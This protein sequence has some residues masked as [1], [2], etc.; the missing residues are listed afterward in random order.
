[1]N[2]LII[3]AGSVGLVLGTTLLEAGCH[4]SFFARGATLEAIRTDGVHRQG[5]F[6]PLDFPP[7]AVE[8]AADQYGEFPDGHFDFILISAKTMANA[9][10]SDALAEHRGLLA[11]EG[12][13][14]ILQ[15]GWGNDAE[16]LRNFP[17]EQICSARVITGCQRS[18]PNSSTVTVYTAPLLLGNLYGLDTAPLEPLAAAFCAGGFPCEVTDEVGK[19]LLAK[20]LYNCALN[21]LGAVLGVH[22]GAL[23]ECPETVAIMNDL[24]DEMFAVFDA[25]GLSTWWATADE[26]RAEFY[27]KLVP[28]TY[29]HNSSTLQDIRKKQKTEINTLTGTILSLGAQYHVPVPANTMLYRLIRAMEANY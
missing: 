8:Y 12:K 10:I 29:H 7:E 6:G 4:V 18:A 24:I 3:G 27:G 21:P 26:Y 17:K 5:L 16:Y 14:L 1:M 15:N 25:A 20:L 19:A 22:Y 23:T 13:L 28:D 11:P 2:I 9:A